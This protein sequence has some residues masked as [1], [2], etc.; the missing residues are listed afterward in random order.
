LGGSAVRRRALSLSIP[1]RNVTAMPLPTRRHTSATERDGI[2][3]V[4][5]VVEVQN[6]TFNEIHRENDYGNDAFVE[7]V[8]GEQV[9]GV[10]VGVQVK[11]GVSYEVAVDEPE[12]AEVEF[13]IRSRGRSSTGQ[14]FGLSSDERRAIE[15]YS[16][17]R[18]I[19]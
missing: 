18:A 10:C 8:E 17:Q 19:A 2:N 14:G 16:M 11:S 12:I 6:C 3:F 15:G 9:S 13:E 1:L 4:R 7:L 5:A